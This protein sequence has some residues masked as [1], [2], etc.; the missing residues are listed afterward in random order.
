MFII[1]LDNVLRTSIGLII[2]KEKVFMLKKTRSRQ[3]PAETATN[4][5]Y[6]DDLELLASTPE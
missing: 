1:F 3:Y 2:I 4:A 5:D 6:A